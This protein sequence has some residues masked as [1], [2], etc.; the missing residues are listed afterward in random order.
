MART[1]SIYLQD[2]IDKQIGLRGS[3]RSETLNQDLA[4]YYHLMMQQLP[5]FSEAEACLLLDVCNGVFFDPRIIPLLWAQVA[6]AIDLYHYDKQWGI[7][8]SALIEK[9]RALSPCQCTAVV[10]AIER[11]WHGDVNESPAKLLKDVGL[12]E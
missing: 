10:D 6:D 8:G 1:V 12:I 2:S 7:D 5:K 4:R 9:L 11:A 3:N